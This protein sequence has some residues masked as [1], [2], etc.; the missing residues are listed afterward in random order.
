MLGS[1][2]GAMYATATREV[3]K[4]ETI[5]ASIDFK[6]DCRMEADE[7]FIAESSSGR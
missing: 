5:A 2:N 7:V 4:I 6:S 1:G 3:S